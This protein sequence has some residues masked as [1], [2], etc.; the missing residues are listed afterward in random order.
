M[1]G[2]N[3]NAALFFDLVGTLVAMDDTR[4]LP[5]DRNGDIVIEVLPG[6]REKLAPIRDHLI[7][8]ITNQA[9]IKRGRLKS[10]KVENALAE[11]DAKLGG[12]LS[13]WQVCPH[14]DGDECGCRKPKAG[15]ITDLAEQY[16]V[17]LK[18]ST[19]VGDQ[20]IDRQASRAA[21]VGNFIYAKDFFGWK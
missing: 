13:A 1:T 18:A 7:F 21:G 19:V 8:V 5:L 2:S 14:D 6:V 3:G 17:D 10:E 16:G 12:I 15:M 4:Q 9:G 11:L 20:E